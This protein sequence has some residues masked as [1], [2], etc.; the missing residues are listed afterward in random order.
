MAAKT[1]R[2]YQKTD[3]VI[4]DVRKISGFVKVLD[5]PAIIDDL[6]LDAN[7]RSS[8]TNSV[9]D[10][11]QESLVTDSETFPF[12]TKGILLGS[13]D[14][15][16]LDRDR[17]IIKPQDRTIEGI[18]DGGHNTL[19]LGLYILSNAM[20]YC[21]QVYN[22]RKKNWDDFKND[23]I[24]YREFVDQYL[25]YCKSSDDT[26][27]AV[28]TFVPIELLVPRD[29]EDSQC[30][31][32][33]R[34][35]LLEICAARNTNVQLG[36]QAKDNQSGLYDSLREIMEAR[37]P[38]MKDKV[39]WKPNE[40]TGEIKATDLITLSWIPLSLV[41]GIK[42]ADGKLIKAPSPQQL[43]SGAGSCQKSYHRLMSSPQVTEANG[44]DYKRILINEEVESAFKIAADLPA[45]YDYVYENF[46][47]AY[48]K[49]GGQYG[50][51][52]AVKSLNEKKSQPYTPY[53]HK[54]VKV[55]N[56]NGFI[57]P[58]VYSLKALMTRAQKQ[59]GEYEIKWLV[60]NPVEFLD[61]HFY[62]VVES[63]K[64]LFDICAYDPQKIGK[65]KFCYEHC[66]TK[67]EGYLRDDQL[68][69]RSLMH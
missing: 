34:N 2:F 50:R 23:W 4:G 42:D 35:N 40:G 63:Y 5:I 21:K 52:S 62:D 56:P 14:Y 28:N 8:K 61:R 57:L 10:A 46:P 11:I 24:T 55:R 36:L 7:P 60:S 53:T 1:I 9:T 3:Q 15:E 30:I 19:A 51:V 16:E 17:Y 26:A 20:D 33:F 69:A 38:F 32:T 43:Y 64:D 22:P 41:E 45:L 58:L 31:E 54:K 6:D 68:L 65:K 67:M 18:L 49:A 48:N 66:F 12:K 59:N 44:S 39:D 37:N 27:T 29:L 25:N 13:S 47:D